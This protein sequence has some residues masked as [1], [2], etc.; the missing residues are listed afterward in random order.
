MG[1]TLAGRA[2]QRVAV[3]GSGNIGPDVALYFAHILTRHGVPIILHDISQTA[4]DAGR[5]RIHQKLRRGGDTGVFR[6]LE[7]ESVEKNIKF[8]LDPSLLTGCDFV[9]EAVNEDLALKQ[10]VFERT[11]R[12]VPP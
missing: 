8:T 1:F 9:V 5:Q 2:I 4:L 10:G 12:I 6:P 7:I 3:L 11:E